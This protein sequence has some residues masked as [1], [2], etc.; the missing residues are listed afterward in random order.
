MAWE[1]ADPDNRVAVILRSNG[2]VLHATAY[3]DSVEFLARLDKVVTLFSQEVKSVFVSRLGLRYVDFIIPKEG[4]APEDYVNSHLDLD[5]GL[6]EQGEPTATCVSIYPMKPGQLTVRY[7][8]AMGEPK[9]P[10][11]LATTSLDPAPLAKNAKC[12]RFAASL[13]TDRT[14]A[15]SPVERLDLA[16]VRDHFALMRAD[17]RK[18][19]DKAA[20]D[21]ARKVWKTK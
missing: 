15:F 8:R 6:S 21:H 5:L 18:A 19:F 11:D 12:D 1:F 3:S 9:L 10:P 13:D 17:I 16:K 2:V 4:E 20:S 14:I 7:V